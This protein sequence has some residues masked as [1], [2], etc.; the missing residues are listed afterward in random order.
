MAVDATK[1]PTIDVRRSTLSPTSWGTAAELGEDLAARVRE[2]DILLTPSEGLIDRPTVP[3]F[4]SGTTEFFR[5][6]EGAVPPTVR[7][8]VASTDDDYQELARHAAILHLAAIVVTIGAAP[9]AINLIST[10][11]YDHWFRKPD[12]TTLRTQITMHDAAR[13]ISVEL[14]YDGPADA[15]KDT[16]LATL[17]EFLDE[18]SD[19]DDTNGS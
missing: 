1:P 18:R 2:A 19:P 17:K 12:E 14:N 4:P 11:I 3:Y 16:A 5:Y 6:L 7:V 15:F 8:E 10:Y 13:G 9:L